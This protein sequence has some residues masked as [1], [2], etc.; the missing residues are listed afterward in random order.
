MVSITW[1]Q[2]QTPS[3][4][5]LRFRGGW[6]R[7]RGRGRSR[8]SK[9]H[10]RSSCLQ[11]STRQ[12]QTITDHA[13]L[14]QPTPSTP[15]MTTNAY[16][17]YH[18]SYSLTTPVRMWRLAKIINTK[19]ISSVHSPPTIIGLRA[20]PKQMLSAVCSNHTDIPP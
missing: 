14:R 18:P 20:E 16:Q 6:L 3:T 12:L 15:D 1:Y 11:R 5:S 8:G 7:G 19:P 17:H 13:H 10:P 2:T 4:H 9:R